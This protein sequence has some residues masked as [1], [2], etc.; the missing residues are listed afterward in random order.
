MFTLLSNRADAIEKNAKKKNIAREQ[1]FNLEWNKV[2]NFLV[3]FRSLFRTKGQT[4]SKK[5]GLDQV[6]GELDSFLSGRNQWGNSRGIKEASIRGHLSFARENTKERRR[7]RGSRRLPS[8][9][10][11]HRTARSSFRKQTFPIS[12]RG[13]EEKRVRPNPPLRTRMGEE[14]REEPKQRI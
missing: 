3:F 4:F 12:R 13:S 1:Y 8:P 14:G 5:G 6:T 7:N 9:L 10:F 2:L 11:L